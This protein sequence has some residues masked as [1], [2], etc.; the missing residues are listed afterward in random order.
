[1]DSTIK[2][3]EAQEVSVS[4]ERLPEQ[5]V[6]ET[7]SLPTLEESPQVGAVQTDS[8]TN[9]EPGGEVLQTTHSEPAGDSEAVR[10]SGEGNVGVEDRD[11]HVVVPSHPLNSLKESPSPGSTLAADKAEVR[12]QTTVGAGWQAQA[13]S[14]LGLFGKGLPTLNSFRPPFT[15]AAPNAHSAD[16]KGLGREQNPFI[17]P[18]NPTGHSALPS[19]GLSAEDSSE[20]SAFGS[21]FLNAGFGRREGEGPQGASTSSSRGE[22]IPLVDSPL[23]PSPTATPAFNPWSLIPALGQSKTVPSSADPNKQKGTKAPVAGAAPAAKSGKEGI[24]TGSMEALTVEHAAESEGATES[25]TGQGGPREGA[26]APPPSGEEGPLLAASARSSLKQSTAADAA[27]LQ[28]VAGASSLGASLA[29][30]SFTKGLLDGSRSAA[31][32]LQTR[33]RHMVS[34]NKHRYQEGGFD[35]DMTYVTDTIIA[36]GFPAGDKSSG[37]LGYVE[38]WYRNHM[39]DV[40]RFLETNHKGKYKVYNLCSERLYDAALFEGKVAAFPFEDHNCPPLELIMAFCQSAY[41]WMKQGL[42]NIVVVHCKAG[43]ARTGLM[44]SSLLLYVKFFP[45][46]EEVISYYN[47]KRAI[48]SKALVLPSQ[49]RYVKYF[50][51]VL[52][53][54]DGVTPAPRRCILRGI[55]LHRCP[56]WVRPTIVISDHQGVVFSTKKHPRTQDLAPEDLWH[57]SPKKGVMVFAL[58]GERCVAELAGDFKILFQDRYGPFYCWLNT[59]MTQNRTLLTTKDLDQFEK[60]RL[61]SPGLQVEV[62]L[63]NHDAAAAMPR[64]HAAPAAPPQRAPLGPGALSGMASAFQAFVSGGGAKEGQ[65]TAAAAAGVGQGDST[66]QLGA[67][68]GDQPTSS[69]FGAHEEREANEQHDDIFSDSEEEGSNQGGAPGSSHPADMTGGQEPAQ[70]D[71]EGGG[72]EESVAQRGAPPLG[73]AATPASASAS[74]TGFGAFASALTSSVGSMG[75]SAMESLWIGQSGEKDRVPLG[76]ASSGQVSSTQRTEASNRSMPSTETAEVDSNAQNRAELESTATSEQPPSTT[77]QEE[78]EPRKLLTREIPP[79]D[80]PTATAG[81]L[82]VTEKP[83]K[84]TESKESPVEAAGGMPP[85]EPSSDFKAI[86]AAATSTADDSVFTFGD[87]EDYESE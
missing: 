18:K 15:A 21:F 2:D 57:S 30:N 47:S 10:A 55:R 85:L 67:Q 7:S 61:G 13:I 70:G 58:P 5:A 71:R 45:T 69:Q 28:A 6:G 78:A 4:E 9:S 81:D 73:P 68:E 40:I 52:R 64:P 44:V 41:A 8:G 42:D 34:Q 25:R 82:G 63:L 48:D 26:E 49:Q 84:P 39:E 16:A 51:R 14:G 87:E 86:A 37:L 17:Q 35:L 43:M 72:N 66:A 59:T 53:E 77:V 36:M 79:A 3:N 32:A 29:L 62:V 12:Q 19:S 38:G 75:K 11:S 76:S 56:Y 23:E 74:A 83:V 50:E 80:D 65:S 1:M 27:S 54:F 31:K 60:R 24:A 22:S 46:A 20:K 33:A